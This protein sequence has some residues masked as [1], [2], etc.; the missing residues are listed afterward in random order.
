MHEEYRNTTI[1]ELRDQLT[2]FAPKGKKI[3]QADLAESLYNEIESDRSYALDYVCFRVTNYRPQKSSRIN[4][5]G[6]DVR[7]DLR[8]LIEDL[9]DAADIAIDEVSERVPHG[10]RVERNV[11]RRNENDLPLARLRF[12]QPSVLG[13]WS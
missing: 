5:A 10:Q 1:K 9:T 6:N 4:A 2:R 11:Q 3:E 12:G 13:E 8:L 7:H